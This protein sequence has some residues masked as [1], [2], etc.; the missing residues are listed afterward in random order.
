M[1]D[2]IDL[3]YIQG[4]ILETFIRLFV[5]CL[6][7]DCVFGFGHAIGTFKRSVS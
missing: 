6:C 1:Q 3:I 4:N 7:I 5:F 2:I